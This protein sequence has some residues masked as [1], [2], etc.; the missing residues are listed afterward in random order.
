MTAA[1][2]PLLDAEGVSAAYGETRVLESVNIALY[3]G[4]TLAVVGESGSGKSTLARVLSGLLAPVGGTVQLSGR[5]LAAAARGRSRNELRQ[6]QMIFQ[7]PDTSLNPRRRVRDEVGRPL[8]LYEGLRGSAQVARTTRP[9][10]KTMTSSAI[11]CTVA[12]S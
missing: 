2:P 8:A 12:R 7:A 1:A 5:P 10:C 9:R 6:I 11:A 3:E 4:R